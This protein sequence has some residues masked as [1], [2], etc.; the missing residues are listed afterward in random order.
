MC[1]AY[2]TAVQSTGI[3]PPLKQYYLITKR[4]LVLWLHEHAM[5]SNKVILNKWVSKVAWRHSLTDIHYVL[6]CQRSNISVFS[7]QFKLL[8][9]DGFQC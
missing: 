5:S 8:K 4:I 9:V 2:F 6:H 1:S 3:F 7:N